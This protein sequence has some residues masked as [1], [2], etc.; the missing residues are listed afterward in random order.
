MPTAGQRLLAL[1]F[2]DSQ[3][4][5]D[6]TAQTGIGTAFAT[7][8]PTVDLTFTAPTSGK[9]LLT[10]SV[11]MGDSSATNILL[12]R[13]EVYLG[14]DATGSTVISGGDFFDL[15]MPID[16]TSRPNATG[17][18]QYIQT[19]LTAGSTYYFRLLHRAA[20]GG[21]ANISWRSIMAAPLPS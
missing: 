1:D 20:S 4:S 2:T 17:S 16:S 12:A 19:G 5:T 3:L 11:K 14:A 10:W 7:G 15:E 18:N 21:T 13:P 9:V 6:N 8:T